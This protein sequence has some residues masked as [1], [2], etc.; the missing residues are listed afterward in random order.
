MGVGGTRRH[1]VS[2]FPGSIEEL[3]S[4]TREPLWKSARNLL[5]F[6]R[7]SAH[8]V[9]TNQP[10]PKLFTWRSNHANQQVCYFHNDTAAR[11]ARSERFRRRS[12]SAVWDLEDEP[13]QVEVQPWASTEEYHC[14]DRI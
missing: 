7:I 13:C 3:L 10:I 1:R 6:L 12:R 5:D 8:N 9:Y 11:G 4:R 2:D 14:N